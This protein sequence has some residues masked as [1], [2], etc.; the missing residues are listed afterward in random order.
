MHVNAK[1]HKPHQLHGLFEMQLVRKRPHMHANL[2]MNELV[3]IS[4]P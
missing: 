1:E 2:S 4:C 3:H